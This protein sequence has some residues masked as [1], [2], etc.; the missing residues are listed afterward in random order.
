MELGLFV[1]RVVV[2]LLFVGHGAQKLFGLFGGHRAVLL[3]QLGA[4]G[5]I[6]VVGGLLIAAGIFTAPVAFICSGEMAA[7]Y[8]KA[9]FPRG[10]LPI[11]NGGEPAV[12]F[13]FIFLYIA[14]R[15]RK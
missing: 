11:Q 1:I 2:G 7:A 9:H 6:E 15:G 10:V 13:C 5:A 14:T 8:F 12:L 3:S 4:A